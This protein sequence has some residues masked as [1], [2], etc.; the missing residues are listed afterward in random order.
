MKSSAVS[1]GTSAVLLVA[2]DDIHR[3]VYLHHESVNNIYIGDSSVNTANGFHIEK[4][5]SVSIVLPSRQTLYAIAS[6]ADQE[7][8]LLTPDTD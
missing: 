6:H 5:Q 4:N 8:R 2:A 3:T 1:V 7:I